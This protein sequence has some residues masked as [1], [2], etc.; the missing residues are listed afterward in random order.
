MPDTI[1][2]KMSHRSE[3]DRFRVIGLSAAGKTKTAIIRERGFSKDFVY[4][5]YGRRDPKDAPHPGR[6]AK[7]TPPVVQTVR[8]LMKGKKQ[9][10]KRKV[11]KILEEKK[12]IVLSHESVRT[13]AHRAG[14]TAYH[15]R[16]KPLLTAEQRQR[17]LN[18]ANLYADTDWRHVLF[19]DEKTFTLFGHPN[20]QNDVIWETSA[21]NVPFNVS[22]KHPAKTQVWGAASYYGVLAPYLF[23][24]SLTAPLY[25][26][27]LK[28]R[29]P[30][31]PH[32]FPD[33]VWMYLHDG[34]TK[35]TSKLARNWMDA[36]IPS[37][38]PKEHWPPNSPDLNIVEP[39]WAHVQ[40]R[41]YARNPRTM[42]G[43]KRIIR[44]EWMAIDPELLHRLV[45]SM[46]D[47]LAAVIA[48]DGGPTKY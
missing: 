32:L 13:A 46:P 15:K 31:A 45:D 38:I 23:N 42:D 35:H 30:A 29:L 9:R 41:V 17:R 14:L 16:Q 47:R 18:F 7:L 34:D 26:D 21:Q 22:V 8:A 11:A 2:F 37:Y 48:A 44:E 3:D 33:G 12:H 28:A 10:S 27:I 24:E 4:R 19:S 40:N 36:N 39:L 25:V 6:P 43:L 20:R 1:F 5:W